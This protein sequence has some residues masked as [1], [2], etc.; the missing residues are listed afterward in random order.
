[1]ALY[2]TP[3]DKHAT[4]TRLRQNAGLDVN[5]LKQTK[6]KITMKNR[7][8][9]NLPFLSEILGGVCVFLTATKSSIPKQSSQSL[10]VSLQEDH[11][12]KTAL[13]TVTDGLL[14]SADK[15]L[16]SLLILLDLSA[17]FNEVGNKI[18][19]GNLSLTFGNHETT[20][21][22]FTSYLLNRTVRS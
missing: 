21:K 20:F 15:R 2:L 6:K 9:S 1:M 17:A 22:W 10:S 8:L 4:V 13:L 3:L 7:P 16:V 14:N 18:L 19:L 5:K 12:T 11:T